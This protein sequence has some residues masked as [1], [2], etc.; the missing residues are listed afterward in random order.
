[1]KYLCLAREEEPVLDAL[2]REE[3]RRRTRAL[4]KLRRAMGTRRLTRAHG[5]A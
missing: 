3:W 5:S 1:M 2:S 4:S